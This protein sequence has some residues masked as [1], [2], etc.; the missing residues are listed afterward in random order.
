MELKRRAIGAAAGAG[1]VLGRLGL[2]VLQDAGDVFAGAAGFK[3][4][5]NHP[6]VTT[7]DQL[8]RRDP[9]VDLWV[10]RGI[11]VKLP[12]QPLKTP[13][14]AAQEKTATGR[15]LTYTLP[16]GFA[17]SDAQRAVEAIGVALRGE[18]EVVWT[19]GQ[20]HVWSYE[21]PLPDR[22]EWSPA[23]ADEAAGS[24]LAFPAG[25]SRAGL[26]VI[27]LVRGPYPHM[28][29][30]GETRMGKSTF[31]RQLLASLHHLH[32]PEELCLHLVDLK[33]GVELAPFGRSCLVD[34]GV[35]TEPTHALEVFETLNTVTDSRASLLV[36][37]GV[38]NLGAY[39][40]R[41]DPLPYHLLLVDELAELSPD[42]VAGKGEKKQREAAH[43]ALTRLLRMA[44]FVGIH[45]IAGTQRPDRDTLPG[46]MKNNIGQTLSFKMRDAVNSQIVLGEGNARAA[47]LPPKP[48]RGILQAETEREIQ[49]PWISLDDVK[50][51][52][53]RRG[54]RR[55]AAQEEAQG[56]R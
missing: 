52:I 50:A 51:V 4:P 2:A 32:A 1:R 24:P 15:H 55:A 43:M 45:V 14:L 9:L 34:E 8:D 41:N 29:V 37:A 33:G 26:E 46:P 12:N 10:A 30:A 53:A 38:E 48:G 40:Q 31:F 17:P 20:L 42:A 39:N 19:G 27:D 22:I 54:L 47:Y 23:L 16:A 5:A 36:H 6:A 13:V 18:A 21:H 56:W 7:S 44:R 25:Y 3:A 11:T 35:A 28:L 49:V